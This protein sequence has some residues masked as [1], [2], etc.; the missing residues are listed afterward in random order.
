MWKLLKISGHFLKVLF[1]IALLIIGCVIIILYVME[2]GLPDA[3][4]KRVEKK[5]SS[6]DAIVEIARITYTP[7]T[8]VHL[9]DVSVI[10]RKLAG[11]R[12]GTAED[13]IIDV[14]LI[15]LKD[16]EKRIPRCDFQ[17]C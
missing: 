1:W 3:I 12:F 7:S 10:P 5:L 15:S 16:K 8:G 14:A 2:N 13:V 17:G 6:D 11:E 9:Y 4:V